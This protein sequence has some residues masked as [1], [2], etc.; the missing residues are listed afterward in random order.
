MGG[1]RWGTMVRKAESMDNERDVTPDATPT[2]LDGEQLASLR[3][4][5]LRFA[6]LQ[7]QNEALA[8]DAVQEALLG[9]FKNSGAFGGKAAY[10]TWVFA[11]LKHKIA[12]LLR[13]G[14]RYV[15]AS[16]LL[17]EC[18]EAEDF[19]DL[20]F[21]Q[22]GH[23]RADEAP[24]AWGN[25]EEAMKNAQF[26]EIFEVCLDHLPGQ[27]GRVFMMREFIELDTREIC[28]ALALTV[29]NLNVMLYRARL[30]LRDCLES[31]W[32]S[33]GQGA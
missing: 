10:K 9:A 12:D 24:C 26:W 13:Q 30:R 33:T 32:F 28:E 29:T 27:Q 2:W 21:D 17:H 15:E 4:Q 23:W 31:R 18:E 5:M 22:R 16:E 11:I 6:R 7:L 19:T 1:K 8:E 20:F 25:P 3:R 14:Q